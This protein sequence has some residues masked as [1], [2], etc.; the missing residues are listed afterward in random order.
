MLDGLLLLVILLIIVAIFFLLFLSLNSRTIFA[1][2]AQTVRI[3]S[4][5]IIIIGGRLHLRI[6][7]RQLLIMLFLALCFHL[8]KL[9]CIDIC[10]FV[11]RRKPFLA[12]FLFCFSIFSLMISSTEIPPYAC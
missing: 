1:R 4:L 9:L 2:A 3:C 11:Q 8:S 10:L 5:R 12:R 6:T 7:V